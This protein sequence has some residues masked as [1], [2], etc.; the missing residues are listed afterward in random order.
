MTRERC[1]AAVGYGQSRRVTS[2]RPIFRPT[3]WS[4]HPVC[5]RRWPAASKSVNQRRPKR[6]ERGFGFACTTTQPPMLAV[7]GRSRRAPS[8]ATAT[9]VFASRLP[10]NWCSTMAGAGITTA[11]SQRVGGRRQCNRQSIAFG[12]PGGFRKISRGRSARTGRTRRR[13][14]ERRPPSQRRSRRLAVPCTGCRC[15]RQ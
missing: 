14:R 6:V 2:S 8:C 10:A 12:Q 9:I 7:S 1:R 13:R 5:R 4:P 11:E 3:R 15:S